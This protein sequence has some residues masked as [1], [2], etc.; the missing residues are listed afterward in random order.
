MGGNK[1]N[2]GFK[3]VYFFRQLV[4]NSAAFVCVFILGLNTGAPTVL[5]PQLRQEANSTDAVT[6]EQASWLPAIP[7]Y[8][9]IPGLIVQN[10][11]AANFGRKVTHAIASVGSLVGFI[12][13]Y[14]S[15]N[16]ETILYSQLFQGSFLGPYVLI[17]TIFVAE[18]TSSEY[19]GL[20]LTIKAATFTWGILTA[21]V[22]DILESITKNSTAAYEDRLSMSMMVGEQQRTP[23][24]PTAAN[25]SHATPSL[26]SPRLRQRACMTQARLGVVRCFFRF[27]KTD[28]SEW[29]AILVSE[30]RERCL[31]TIRVSSRL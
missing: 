24:E 8:A 17:V 11:I 7:S 3:S 30:F 22:L 14:C 6:P 28:S 16:V 13:F 10:V 5:V 21:N 31:D 23:C 26:Q 27:M 2:S 4:I 25:V 20:F 19:R 15:T 1:S 29:L 9:T 18:Y 12:I